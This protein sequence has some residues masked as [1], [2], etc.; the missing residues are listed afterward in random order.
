MTKGQLGP[1]YAQYVGIDVA[2]ETAE[3]AVQWPGCS[4]GQGFGIVQTEQGLQD[5]TQRLLARGQTAEQTLVVMEANGSYL[6]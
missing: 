2:A 3:V 5:L 4:E 6:K 1:M